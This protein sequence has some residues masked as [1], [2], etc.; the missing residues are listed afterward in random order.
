LSC[1]KDGCLNKAS[2][3]IGCV[4][5]C[6][7]VVGCLLGLPALAQ[8]AGSGGIALDMAVETFAE[9]RSNPQLN[10]ANPQQL[11]QI[12]SA[13][14][15]GVL[16][17]TGSQE[18][19]LTGGIS[20]RATDGSGGEGVANGV[21]DP[22]LTL[23]YARQARD[24]SLSFD[25]RFQ[26][27][28]LV[29]TA[30]DAF[31]ASIQ[32]GTA[33]QREVGAEIGLKWRET[34]PLGFGVLA[35]VQKTAFID[36][37][38]F[39]QGGQV[40]RGTTRH[41][42]EAQARF[43]L[44]A[45]HHLV[46]TMGYRAFQQEATVGR[47][48]SF[49][50]ENMYQIDRPRGPFAVNLRYTKTEAGHRFSGMLRRELTLPDGIV[51]AGIGAA[52][53]ATGGRY[54]TGNLEYKTALVRGSF[55]FRARRDLTSSDQDDSEQINTSIG[56]RYKFDATPLDGITVD[57]DWAEAKNTQSGLTTMNRVFAISYAREL[58]RTARFN[59]GLRRRELRDSVTGVGRSNEI[60][61]SF[62]RKFSARF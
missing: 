6:W 28:D 30:P 10:G 48:E 46:A 31:G 59:I 36:G 42:V 8:G 9:G 2:A 1:P 61:M 22:F 5:R 57:I 18:L 23:R 38:A 24:A 15:F 60:F 55:E 12:G 4:L 14:A 45:A 51:R 29:Q 62:R 49:H 41:R 19:S 11:T 27:T 53:G 37:T 21:V 33:K 25:L 47:R 32:T 40:L 17:Q 52:R 3:V 26:E 50:L 7:G 39:G 16:T 20:L 54:V 34:A 43:D 56:V 44:D 35:S 13:F 58:S